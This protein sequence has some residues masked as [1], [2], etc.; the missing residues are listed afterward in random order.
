M[1]CV[2]AV[3]D[4][5]GD[6]R[7]L[8]RRERLLL[9]HRRD[10]QDVVR[11]QVLALRVREVRPGSSS[12]RTSRAGRL[13]AA[14][15]SS[16]RGSRRSPG[17]GTP[18]GSRVSGGVKHGILARRVARAYVRRV[19]RDRPCRFLRRRSSRPTPTRSA[20]CA[21]VKPSGKMMRNG[22]GGGRQRHDGLR[23]VDV[24]QRDDHRGDRRADG[25]AR[26]PPSATMRRRRTC[27]GDG[28]R[29]RRT[30]VSGGCSAIPDSRSAD[31]PR[32]AR[33]RRPP[34]PR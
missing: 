20:I 4:D 15:T 29:G 22:F 11:R 8:L 33:R 16:S 13:R 7:P 14:A 27:C 6:L 21:R 19:E 32:R 3:V 25:D 23:A 34:A 5:G 28:P 24:R 30:G 18:R 10:D 9:D 31:A 2:Q 26:S 12:C 17:R 1:C